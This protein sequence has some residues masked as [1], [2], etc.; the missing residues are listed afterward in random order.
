MNLRTQAFGRQSHVFTL[1]EL[2]VVISII[3]LLIAILLPALARA[4]DAARNSQCMSNMRQVFLACWSYAD[5]YKGKF[6]LALTDDSTTPNYNKMMWQ[7]RL[8]SYI[9]SHELRQ[10]GANTANR[11][12]PATVFRCPSA[13]LIEMTGSYLGLYYSH[14]GLNHC[15]TYN[16]I[17]DWKYQRDD[18]RLIPSRYIAIAEANIFG[19]MSSARSSSGIVYNGSTPAMYRFSHLS[20]STSNH[21]FLD[22]HVENINGVL[23]LWP[24]ETSRWTWATNP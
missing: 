19:D 2:L 24:V 22:G 20:N 17:P 8:I 11:F 6:P 7:Q 9:P 16:D 4:R 13:E 12:R 1:I 3:A 18:V 10:P 23:P 5:D 14:Y 21:V 15:M